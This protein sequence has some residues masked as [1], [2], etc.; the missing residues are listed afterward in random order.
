[1]DKNQYKSQLINFKTAIQV[2][3]L[4]TM[5]RLILS[6]KQ[7][8]ITIQRMCHQLVEN[9]DDFSNS[10][11]IGLQPRG[12]FLSNRIVKQLHQWMPKKKLLHGAL[13]ITFYR[14]D[15][16]RNEKLIV[17]SRTEIDFVVEGKNVILVDDVLFTGRTIRAAMDALLAF[18]R[19]AKVELLVLIDRKFSRELPIEPD[20]TGDAIDSIDSDKVNVEWEENGKEDGVWLVSKTK[21]NAKKTKR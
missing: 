7:M 11:I 9:H 5:T 3:H 15:Y 14:D 17:P 20:Y 8:G 10:C 1:M 4:R 18:G 16:R 21:S 19:P 12:V 2:L 13:D 6:E